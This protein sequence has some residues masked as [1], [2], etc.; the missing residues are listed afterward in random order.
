MSIPHD[1]SENAARPFK[2]R[3]E[4]A[5]A[6]VARLTANLADRE[7][8]F[9]TTV[10]NLTDFAHELEKV[11]KDLATANAD[12]NTFKELSQRYAKERDATAA[13]LKEANVTIERMKHDAPLH[14]QD[15]ILTS[16][17]AKL[18]AKIIVLVDLVSWELGCDNK[19]QT[20]ENLQ[21]LI[22]EQECGSGAPHYK[23]KMG[24]NKPVTYLKCAQCGTPLVEDENGKTK[25][26]AMLLGTFNAQ[27]EEIDYYRHRCVTQR[28]DD[29]LHAKKTEA[30][31]DKAGDK[32]I[33]IGRYFRN[34]TESMI[35]KY[36]QK[37]P[38]RGDSWDD[39]A[40]IPFLHTQLVEHANKADWLDVAVFAMFLDVLNAQPRMAT[41]QLDKTSCKT[42]DIDDLM[43]SLGRFYC[44]GCDHGKC[45]FIDKPG[46]M[47]PDGFNMPTR[48]HKCKP[49]WET[50]SKM[51]NDKPLTAAPQLDLHILQPGDHGYRYCPYRDWYVALLE[52]IR[53]FVPLTNPNFVCSGCDE[54]CMF[55]CSVRMQDGIHADPSRCVVNGDVVDWKSLALSDAMNPQPKFRVDVIP[56]SDAEIDEHIKQVMAGNFE[57]AR[58]DY[59]RDN[60]DWM[61]T[62]P[63]P[64]L[65]CDELVGTSCRID[66]KPCV[67]CRFPKEG[68]A[69]PAT[70]PSVLER[71]P[72]HPVTI[73]DK[74]M[75]KLKA[76]A[77]SNI[78]G[79]SHAPSCDHTFKWSEPERLYRCVKCKYEV[80]EEDWGKPAAAPI[81]SRVRILS[82]QSILIMPEKPAPQPSEGRYMPDPHITPADLIPD[83]ANVPLHDQIDENVDLM[84]AIEEEVAAETPAPNAA[85]SEVLADAKAIREE[86]DFYLAEEAKRKAAAGDK[87]ARVLVYGKPTNV[88]LN[89]TKMNEA[90][91]KELSE[92]CE[93]GH[94][95]SQHYCDDCYECG[96]REF[97]AKGGDPVCECGHQMSHHQTSLGCIAKLPDGKLCGCMKH[98]KKAK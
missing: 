21:T 37:L 53:P 55:P 98:L 68:M 62:K 23:A 38:E 9:K 69:A 82:D 41:P 27:P 10:D 34:F 94:P 30:R 65:H 44:D 43:E 11:R 64:K 77:A 25:P 84:R 59:L 51:L 13:Q 80:K 88:V 95:K 7:S 16:E 48:I 19:W 66:G 56:T 52:M 58:E 78:P 17:Y 91:A 54:V 96:C 2:E 71:A 97:K 24:A 57:H 47:C 18:E 46:A 42:V 90:A 81:K 74:L 39:V 49:D 15:Y 76:P 14:W 40:E 4:K 50:V 5:E 35:A 26:F 33:I 67:P 72:V 3:A 8:L 83:G 61:E 31:V 75:T 20:C 45:Y 60:P 85:V 22:C 63:L 28:L 86:R 36:L 6:D 87:L 12:G 70:H 32:S 93:C 29:K 92:V 1:A 79:E 89:M 73:M